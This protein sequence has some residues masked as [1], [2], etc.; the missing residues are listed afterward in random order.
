MS[1]DKVKQGL[2]PHRMSLLV[3]IEYG[4]PFE[5]EVS[6]PGPLYQRSS[7]RRRALTA[8]HHGR[9]AAP[10]E[11]KR[12]QHAALGS[13]VLAVEGIAGEHLEAACGQGTDGM[14]TCTHAVATL[15]PAGR[16]EHAESNI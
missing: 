1:L 8:G 15:L 3:D 4:R 5:V 10:G 13:Y 11:T 6:R 9:G 7:R 16:C 14:M 2:P 12:T